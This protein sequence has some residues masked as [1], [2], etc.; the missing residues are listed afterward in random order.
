MKAPR[1]RLIQPALVDG[2]VAGNLAKVLDMIAASAGK[3][4][5]MVF[6]ETCISGFPTIDT[7]Q[8]LAEPLDGSSISAVRIA[9][10]NAEVSVAI[11]FAEVGDGHYFNS[12]VLIDTDGSVL[13][14]YRKSCLY[15]SDKGVFEAGT[16]FPVCTWHGIQVGLLICFDIE[17]PA[18]SY[19][20]ARHGAELIVLVDGLMHPYGPMHRHAV[21]VRALDNQ[22]FIV[23]ANRVGAGEQYQFS[24]ESHAAD[25]FGETLALASNEHE[26][27]LDV[28]LDMMQVERARS[29]AHAHPGYRMDGT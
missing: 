8:K 5:L 3:T 26:A 22:V 2:D 23:M 4:D 7:V 10:R 6:P 24:G 13:L 27:V 28:V 25:P 14:H 9:A 19:K 15:D 20:L 29:A 16:A 12:V 1:I 17:F 18:P 11:G 21:P